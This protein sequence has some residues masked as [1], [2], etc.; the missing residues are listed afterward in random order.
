MQH[1]IIIDTDIG[2]DIDDI[3]VTA[4]ALNSPEFEVL[5][6]TTVDGDTS[7]RSRIARRLTAAYG[8]PHIPVAAGYP[9]S[10]P[11]RDSDVA[12]G[13]SITQGEIAPKERGLPH[14]SPLP[15]DE[16]IAR[17]TAEH[18]GQVHVLTIGAMTNIG[19]AFLRFP[20]TVANVRAVVT[21][22]GHF[23]GPEVSVGWNLRYDPVAASMVAC[24]GV[25]WTLLSEGAM[26]HAALGADE[27]RAIHARRLATTDLLARAIDLWKRNKPDAT[28]LP[29]VSDLSVFAYLLNPDW[30][31]ARHGRATV[32][33]P[34]EDI[35]ALTVEYDAEGPHLLVRDMSRAGG[36][37][38]R[39]LFM[40][41]LLA[42]PGRVAPRS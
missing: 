14:A 18:I 25:E 39:R 5:A 40:E 4:F 26:R 11:R 10:M 31:F 27:V 37:D 28:P 15:A 35:A 3:L 1:R 6:I 12:P 21:N 36:A 20:E 9:H 38:V 23:T 8:K 34:R 24:S 17:L 19:Q 2:E 7:A 13:T 33:T 16:L 41:R 22:G 42:P 30:L 32:T 29:H